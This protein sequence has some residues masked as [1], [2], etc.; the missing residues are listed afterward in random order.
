MKKFERSFP[1]F[2]LCGLNCGLCTMHLGNYCP[3]CGGGDGNKPCAIARCS[4]Q[5][6]KIEYCYLCEKY[7]CEKYDG[8]DKFDSFITHRNQIKDFEKVKKIGIDAY[9]SELDEKIKILLFLLDNYNDGRRKSF[10]SLAV[11]LLELKDIKSVME[12]L[13]DKTESDYT[14]K[15]KA[16]LAVDLFNTMAAKRNIVLKLNKKPNDSKNVT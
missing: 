14:I 1:L 4:Q 6:E 12:Q 7:P 5:N 16:A 11:N 13:T 15:E 2:S 10:F 3:G 9:K 8:I